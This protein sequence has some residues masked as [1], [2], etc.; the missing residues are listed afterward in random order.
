MCKSP[1]PVYLLI[2]N[3]SARLTTFRN[4]EID[5][6]VGID[7]DVQISAFHPWRFGVLARADGGDGS[8]KVLRV[9][10]VPVPPSTP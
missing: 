5:L 6:L 8:G 1:S 3:D 2:E 4:G 7:V 10:P 9:T